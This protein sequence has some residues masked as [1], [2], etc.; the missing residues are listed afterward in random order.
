M[1]DFFCNVIDMDITE[2][3]T[4]DI[5]QFKSVPT[6]QA[7]PASTAIS[8]T[9]SSWFSSSSIFN[10]YTLGIVV[11]TV[12]MFGAWFAWDWYK[13]TY[14]SK[15]NEESKEHETE[16]ETENRQPI[17]G[18]TVNPMSEEKCKSDQR[19]LEA[20]LSTS[21]V[22]GEPAATDLAETTGKAG[23]CY[24]GEDQGYNVC[25][26]VQKTDRCLS[27]K[28]FPTESECRQR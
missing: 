18:D 5:N 11:I 16:H 22:G 20:A 9:E 26:S 3:I 4:R 13:T 1:I 21:Q 8:S 23:W 12:L 19:A 7:P 17:G 6:S 14:K 2:K 25:S 15:H 10:Y 24:I 28:V 27:G